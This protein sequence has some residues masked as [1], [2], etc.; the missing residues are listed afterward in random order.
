MKISEKKSRI[1]GVRRDLAKA[2]KK[3]QQFFEENND[4]MF[5]FYS[6]VVTNLEE[7]LTQMR[8]TLKSRLKCQR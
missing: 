2:R 4:E 7:M 1:R 8:E 3:Q 6:N 5:D